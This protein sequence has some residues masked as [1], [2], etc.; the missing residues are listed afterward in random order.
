MPNAPVDNHPMVGE[1]LTYRP[2]LPS[3]A[4][5]PVTDPKVVVRP[6]DE[7]IVLSVFHDWNDVP[8]LTIFYVYVPATGYRT[9]V[10]ANEA[11]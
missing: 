11:P 9:H 7:V 10:S 5:E 4:G 3:L 8:G 2:D 1:V 6:G